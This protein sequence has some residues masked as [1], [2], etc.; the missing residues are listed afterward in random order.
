MAAARAQ[1]RLSGALVIGGDR[2]APP[3]KCPSNQ[4][5]PV[6]LTD[7]TPLT[8]LGASG[9]G[10]ETLVAH[11]E[12]RGCI[13]VPNPGQPNWKSWIICLRQALCTDQPTV[14]CHAG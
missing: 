11:A 5:I 4:A 6:N 9:M 8:V 1:E 14:A 12:V 7:T 10:D 3:E 2:S 13:R